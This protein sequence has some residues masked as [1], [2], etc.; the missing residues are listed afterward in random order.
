MI[1]NL[2]GIVNDGGGNGRT[3]ERKGIQEEMK[4]EGR[5]ET[6]EFIQLRNSTTLM[7]HC[8]L[9]MGN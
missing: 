7:N 4:A 8:I 2:S 5:Y 9:L 3:L 1:N 6:S